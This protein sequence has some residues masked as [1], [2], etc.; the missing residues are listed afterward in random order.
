MMVSTIRRAAM[1]AVVVGLIALGMAV[2]GRAHTTREANYAVPSF[3]CGQPVTVAITNFPSNGKQ[4]VVTVEVKVNGSQVSS[5]PVSFTGST[6]TYKSSVTVTAGNT[7][8]VISTWN[9]NGVS[10]HDDSG[11]QKPTGAC[12][13]VTTTT[14]ST[15]P[16][17]TTAVTTTTTPTQTMTV[18]TPAPPA[19]TT[20]VATPAP[21]APRITCHNGYVQT[22]A[23]SCLK[24]V[25]KVKVRTVVKW[26]TRVVAKTRVVTRVVKPKLTPAELCVSVKGNTWT[27]VCGG[28]GRG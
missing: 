17:T 12:A 8:E 13:A 16:R 21:A 2:A 14:T 18:T 7:Y 15:V 28:V 26:R 6:F 19:V 5:V 23:Y 25:T 27:G 22:G 3:T 9:G 4:N 10:G 20:T 1:G 24:T 11:A